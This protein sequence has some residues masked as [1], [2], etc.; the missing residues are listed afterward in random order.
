MVLTKGDVIGYDKLVTKYTIIQKTKTG[1]KD[2]SLLPFAQ[3]A[4]NDKKHANKLII[5]HTLGSHYNYQDR[6]TKSQEKFKPIC[7]KSNIKSCTKE[8]L[9]N[10]YD[11][12]IV[13]V[14][15]FLSNLIKMLKDKK[16]ILIYTS[17][18]GESLGKN[19]I[20]FHGMPINIAPK[21]QRDV[22]L[23]FWF[24]DSYK[25]SKNGEKLFSNIKKINPD[26]PLSHDYILDST[27]G[28]SSISSNN[29]GVNSKYNLCQEKR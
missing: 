18:H 8:E 7:K 20:Y 9:I 2:I 29:G 1:T 13:G 25:A 24:S 22:P 5:L 6:V 14:D 19:G 16:A 15:Q 26:T 28:C 21:S 11:N 17:D 12:S 3:K 23:M 4:I 10:S 27:L